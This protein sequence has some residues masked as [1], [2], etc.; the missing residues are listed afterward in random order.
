[1]RDAEKRKRDAERDRVDAERGLGKF[2]AE[3]GSEKSFEAS[4]GRSQKPSSP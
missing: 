2:K 4:S 3:R 1:M